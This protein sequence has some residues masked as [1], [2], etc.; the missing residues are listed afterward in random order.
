MEFI[1]KQ[2]EKFNI[3]IIHG[4]KRPDG[5]CYGS[6]LGLKDIIKTNY[7]DKRVYVVGDEEKKISFLGNMDKITD[8]VYKDALV[9]IVDCGNS[10]NISDNRYKLGKMSIRIDHHLFLNKIADYEWIDSNFASCSE[11]IYYFKK[12]HNYKLTKKGALPI[13]TGIVTDTDNFRFERVNE[14]TFQYAIDLL[15]Y[16][17]N[18]FDIDKQ[19]HSQ[20]VNLLKFKGYVCSNFI[21]DGGFIYFK[22][23]EETLE[24]FNLTIEEAFSIVNVL[25]YIENNPVWGFILKLKNGCYKISIRSSRFDVFSIAYKFG[26]GGHKKACG[27]FVKNEDVMNKVIQAIKESIKDFNSQQQILST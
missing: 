6:Q 13:Y 4:H 5:D 9:F 18:V 1:R 26:G 8:D 17:L 22:F 3:I 21:I 14:K 15:Q 27:I 12:F 11:M 23:C 25:N 7:P 16:G 24:K 10:S 20:S 2:I 19:I